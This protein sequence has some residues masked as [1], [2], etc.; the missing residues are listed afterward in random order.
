MNKL[1]LVY[2]YHR[3][4]VFFVLMLLFMAGI[5]YGHKTNLPITPAFIA[6]VYTL[7]SDTRKDSFLT[8]TVNGQTPLNLFHTIDEPRRMMIYSTLSAYHQGMLRGKTDPDLALIDKTVDKH[9]FLRPL[10]RAIGCRAADYDHYLPWLLRYIRASVSDTINMLDINMS[11]IHY[12]ER[13][14][15]IADSTKHLYHIE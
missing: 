9:P 7:K 12:T 13:D 3:N 5:L 14:L 10:R 8:I 1:Y 15:P 6:N 11:Y 2:C 4:K